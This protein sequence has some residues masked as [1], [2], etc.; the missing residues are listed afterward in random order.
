MKNTRINNYIW[1]T[2]NYKLILLYFDA[3]FSFEI[4]ITYFKHY[5]IN[6]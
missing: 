6:D 4:Q 3:T 2:S 1:Y 5:K